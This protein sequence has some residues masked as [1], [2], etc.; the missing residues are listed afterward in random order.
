[1]ASYSVTLNDP[2]G[3]ATS[4]NNASDCNATINGWSNDGHSDMKN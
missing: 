3:M 1:M 4:V 2:I